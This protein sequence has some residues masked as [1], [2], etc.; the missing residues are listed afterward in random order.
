[1]TRP[2]RAPPPSLDGYLARSAARLPDKAALACGGR[3]LTYAE[4]AGA[5]AALA[6]A[7]AARGVGRGDRVVVFMDNSAEAAVSFWGVLGAGA[8]AV[9][10]NPLTKADK[11]AYLIA[12]S[13]ARALLTEAH[14]APAFAPAAARSPGLAACLVAG[15]LDPARLAARPP[16]LG[17]FA[18]ALAEGAPPPPR[19]ADP[20]DLAALIYTSGTT[21][22][23][24]GVMHE[25]RGLVAAAES[26]A[27]YLEN[28]ED[29]VCLG[30]LPLAF[31]YGLFQMIVAFAVGARLVLERG[32]AYPA[33]VLE[34]MAAERV[35][36]FAGVPALYAMLAGMASI[37]G[38]DFSSVR[39]LTNAAAALPSK[40]VGRLR[41]IFPRAK[42]F[43]MY[44]Q[45]ECIRACY[46]PPELVDRKPESVGV[47]IPGAE[48]W[49]EGEAG[50][51]LGP[52]EV[53]ELVLRG[54]T[55]MRGYWGRPA[56]TALKLRPGPGGGE[57]VL[58]TGD[59]FRLDGEGH[60]HFV[61]RADD[62]IK[63]RGEK[64]SPREVENAIVAIG[65]VREAA[66]IGVPDPVLGQAVKAFVV[67]EA[68]ASL[69]E[70]DVQRECQ[71]RLESFMVPKHVAFVADL[72]KTDTGK[73]KKTGLA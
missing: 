24:K 4:I 64:V 60:L 34:V 43:S 33:K 19:R 40:H 69:S 49:V 7:L 13:G 72:P 57:R 12:D 5:A 35:T 22:E 56:A 61:A 73:I 18:A 51:R 38:Y 31:G 16:G 42:I 71:Q 62:V 17:A 28:A 47:A 25:H 6:G 26:I 44:G 29:D 41:E 9:M 66:V 70:K 58:H 37:G 23:P 11:L 46:L 50:E 21:G 2:D 45:T 52:G 32:F 65:G 15:A 36:G 3:R 27:A 68:G 55:L 30:V 54:P 63:S 14:L 67:L 48:A 8:V 20:A 39:Y 53:G 1:M 59:R 10:V